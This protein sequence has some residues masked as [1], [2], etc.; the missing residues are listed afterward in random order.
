MAGIYEDCKPKDKRLFD[1][2]D[3]LLWALRNPSKVDDQWRLKI[4]EKVRYEADYAINEQ[5]Q[6]VCNG[7]CK[8][9]V[10]SYDKD[11]PIHGWL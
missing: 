11:C 10:L 3:Q 5:M 4:L 2:A 7:I 9:T 1:A 6:I 8:P